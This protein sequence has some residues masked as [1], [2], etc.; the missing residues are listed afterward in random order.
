MHRPPMPA[1]ANNSICR[2]P[3]LKGIE[4]VLA[5]M[6]GRTYIINAGIDCTMSALAT[7]E[8]PAV[9]S[10]IMK[11]H[12]TE[13]GRSIGNDAMD[14]QGGKAIISGPSNYLGRAV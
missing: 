13:L 7:G 6:A 14:V 10:A 5:R 12:C 11:Y 3:G 8:I 4:E 2:S 1:S 9:P